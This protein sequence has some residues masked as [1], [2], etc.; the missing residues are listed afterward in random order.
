MISTRKSLYDQVV[1]ITSQYLGPASER[2]ISRQIQ[3]HIGKEPQDLTHKDLEKLI[4]WI[5]LSIALLTEDNKLVEDFSKRLTLLA[6]R[7]PVK[8]GSK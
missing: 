4:D 3:M 8:N 1:E 2:F 5:K 7:K 6:R